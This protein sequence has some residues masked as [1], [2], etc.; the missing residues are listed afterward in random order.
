MILYKTVNVNWHSSRNLSSFFREIE[1]M[2]PQENTDNGDAC[3]RFVVVTVAVYHSLA[4]FLY[5]FSIKTTSLFNTL[6][7]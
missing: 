7:L 2:S 4:G 5:Y 3:L 6:N 1:F